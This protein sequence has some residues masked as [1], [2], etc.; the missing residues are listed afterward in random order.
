MTSGGPPA[1]AGNKPPPNRLDPDNTT[2]SNN[3]DLLS[4]DQKRSENTLCRSHNLLLQIPHDTNEANVP[5]DKD[6]L[7]LSSHPTT[8]KPFSTNMTQ[9]LSAFSQFSP[10]SQNTSNQLL[11]NHH[12]LWLLPHP[13]FL[14]NYSPLTMKCL[15]PLQPLIMALALI[16]PS[17]N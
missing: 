3:T 8:P 7:E 11:I 12:H 17:F 6:L 14:K 15:P 5:S 13:L 9:I 10:D 4:D 16:L 1:G 2:T